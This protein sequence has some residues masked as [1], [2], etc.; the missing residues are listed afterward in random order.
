MSNMSYCRMENT[1][2]DLEDCVENW[3]LTEESSEY[4]ISAK[5]R[6][7]ELAREIIELED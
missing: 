1:S 5:Q 6:I 4:E 7:I 2:K 3:D